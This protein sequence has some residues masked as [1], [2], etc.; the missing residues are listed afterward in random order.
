MGRND[1]CCPLQGGPVA[2]TI[3]LGSPNTSQ[4]PK[5]PDSSEPGVLTAIQEQLGLKL[6]PQLIPEEF[7]VIDHVEMP[8]AE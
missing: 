8:V 6:V 7:L 2:R 5:V 1:G 4:W 3:S